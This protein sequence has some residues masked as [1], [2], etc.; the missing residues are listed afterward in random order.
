M[1]PIPQPILEALARSFGLQPDQLVPFGGGR[2]DSDGVVYAYPYQ[3]RRRLL[4]IMA[5]PAESEQRGLFSLEER[6]RFMRFLG[7]RGA[8]IAFPQLSPQGQLYETVRSDSHLWV[9]YSMEIMPGKTPAW[10]AWDADLFRRWGQTV[11]L[12]HRLTQ[13][14][15]S[16]EASLE[17]GTGARL[18]TWR[19]EWEGFFQWCQDAEVREEWVKIRQ[20]LEGLPD[21]RE[22]FGF[23]HND[24]HRENVLYD[25]EQITLLDFDVANHHWFI[26]DIAIACQGVLFAQSGGLHEPVHHRAKLLEFLAFFREGYELEHRLTSEWWDRLDLFIAY[27]RILLF[28]VMQGWMRTKPEVQATWKQMILSAPEVVGRLSEVSRRGDS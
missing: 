15:P 1:I 18:L 24:P 11:G 12:L 26:S 23:C 25:G 16:W 6:I 19:E 17:P 10:D 8:H 27:R 22:V 14:Y 13:E 2:E 7:E 5:I 3:E 21:R 28:V 20:Q 9:G 4:K